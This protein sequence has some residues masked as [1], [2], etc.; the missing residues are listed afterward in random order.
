ME[1]LLGVT[2]SVTAETVGAVLSTVTVAP[3]V[4]AAVTTFPDASVPT[5]NANVSVP[6]PAGAV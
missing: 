3:D 4:G 2:T 6:F 1:S 5:L